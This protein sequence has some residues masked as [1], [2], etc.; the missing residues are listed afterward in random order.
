[1]S[2]LRW[3]IVGFGAFADLRVGSIVA[4]SPEHELIAIM[5]RNVDKARKYAEKHNVRYYYDS[6]EDLVNNPYVEAV[7][8]ASP[9]YQHCEHTHGSRKRS[10]CTV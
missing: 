2:R 3:G 10:P 5:N 7:Y 1:M 9:N 4:T 8:V 6:V